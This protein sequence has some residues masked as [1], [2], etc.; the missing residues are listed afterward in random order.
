MD[1]SKSVK[2]KSDQTINIEMDGELASFPSNEVIE[3]K[4]IKDAIKV[5]HYD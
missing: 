1:K 5:V 3:I 2:I 4:Y